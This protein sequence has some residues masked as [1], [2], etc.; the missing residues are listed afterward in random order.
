MENPA[1]IVRRRVAPGGRFQI[2]A[3]TGIVSV[4]NGGLLNYETGNNYNITIAA[5]DGAASSTQTF[6]IGVTNANPS[7]PTDS[8]VLTQEIKNT[9]FNS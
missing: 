2:D 5:S 3:G 4:A 7:T 6:S 8:N 1:W 9:S